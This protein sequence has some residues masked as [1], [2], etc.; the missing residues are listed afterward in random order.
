MLHVNYFLPTKVLF[1]FKSLHSPNFPFVYFYLSS[2][3]LW[4]L[5]C[6]GALEEE[7][8]EDGELVGR[9]NY[10]KKKKKTV[11]HTWF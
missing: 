11:Q 2:G 8:E 1:V 10:Q 4:V 7:E 9:L 5:G 3:E 6:L